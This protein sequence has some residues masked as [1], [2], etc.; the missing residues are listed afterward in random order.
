MTALTDFASKFN[1]LARGNLYTIYIFP[2]KNFYNIQDNTIGLLAHEATFPYQTFTSKE[3]NFNN[4]NTKVANKIDY[5]PATFSFYTDTSNIING[6]FDA[7]RNEIIDNNGRMGYYDDY[8]SSV[9]IEVFDRRG[10]IIATAH[11]I[12]AWP[13]NFASQT[14]AYNQNDTLL[15]LQVSFNYKKIEYE[16]QASPKQQSAKAINKPK[17]WS[18]FVN[19]SNVRR[20]INLVSKLKSYERTIKNPN[21]YDIIT[22]SQKAFNF[23]R[24]SGNTPHINAPNI[25]NNI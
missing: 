5:D 15:N 4:T 2:N 12:D 18:D 14:L 9:D 8:I 23:N 17:T 6:F 22:N 13:S 3:F 19:L 11:L 10:N 25:F 20:G 1:D 16:F 24:I 7:W 21:A